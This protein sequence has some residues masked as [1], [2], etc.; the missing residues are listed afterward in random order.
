VEVESLELSA[1][2][3][4]LKRIPFFISKFSNKYINSKKIVYYMERRN[5]CDVITEMIKH[6][7]KER[8]DLLSDLEFNYEDSSYKA[9]EENI[10][11][12]RTSE[13]LQKHIPYPQEDWELEVLSIF[14]CLPID[15]IKKMVGEFKKT[16][17]ERY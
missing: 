10:Q 9:P 15:E 4:S 14:S 5:C 3:D 11:W 7:P 6:I 12:Y 16:I 8:S 17:D 13:T 1:L 2:W